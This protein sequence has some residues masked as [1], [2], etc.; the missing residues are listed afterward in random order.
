MATLPE[1]SLVGD[2]QVDVE[3]AIWSQG[4]ARLFCEKELF[5]DLPDEWD[6]H[7]LAYYRSNTGNWFMFKK[8]DSKYAYVEKF[9][10]G[11]EVVHLSK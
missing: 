1:I 7:A 11:H 10:N 4:R 8:I 9:P 5:N 3:R 2:H 6:D